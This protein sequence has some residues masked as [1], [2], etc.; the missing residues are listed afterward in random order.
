MCLVTIYE[1]WTS[2][3]LDFIMESMGK[4]FDSEMGTGKNGRRNLFPITYR[5]LIYN[6]W[7]ASLRQIDKLEAIKE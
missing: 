6:V 3:T 5:I 7:A 4:W 2:V 1:F